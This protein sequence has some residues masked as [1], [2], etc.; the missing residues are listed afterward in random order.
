MKGKKEMDMGKYQDLNELLENAIHLSAAYNEDVN[1]NTMH[2]SGVKSIT[3]RIGNC[4]MEFKFSE[5]GAG[6]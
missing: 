3:V 2:Y 4:E 1:I 5:G 6:D